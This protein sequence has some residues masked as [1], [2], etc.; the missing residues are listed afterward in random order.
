MNILEAVL[1][2]QGGGATA[3]LGQQFGLNDTQVSS[4]LS[5]LVPALAAGFQQH[6]SSP[7]GLE[8]MLSALGGGQ[9]Q[10]YVDDAAALAHPDTVTDGNGI[11][12]HIFGSKDV[13]RQVASQAATQTGLGEGVLKSML[14]VVAAMMMGTMSKHV[15]SAGASQGAAA[16]TGASLLGML[17]PMLDSNRDGSMVDDVIGMLGKF[18]G[19]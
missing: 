15:A 6:M 4:A 5:A 9:H 3:Q 13:S 11:L 16:P 12:G 2:A 10:R 17:T 19:R 14:P 7:Q 1:G 18:T 8:G